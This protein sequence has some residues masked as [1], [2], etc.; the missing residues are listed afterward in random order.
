LN[1]YVKERDHERPVP[2]RV[3][4][5]IR[6]NRGGC[7]DIDVRRIARLPWLFGNMREVLGAAFTVAKGVKFDPR[8][9]KSR[10]RDRVAKIDRLNERERRRRVR[11]FSNY[12]T[13]WCAKHGVRPAP[14]AA[15]TRAVGV[16]LQTLW[17][18]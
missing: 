3:R 1:L 12:G 13:A 14:D 6:F 15:I 18:K 16:A 2:E 5:E 10:R 8:V 11:G 9:T 4:L 7:Q 17:R